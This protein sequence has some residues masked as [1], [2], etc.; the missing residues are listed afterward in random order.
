MYT[1]DSGVVAASLITFV[2]L[3]NPP[4]TQHE[5]CVLPP[6]HHA[7]TIFMTFTYDSGIPII[8]GTLDAAGAIDLVPRCSIGAECARMTRLRVAS[9]VIVTN[10]LGWRYVPLLTMLQGSY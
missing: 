3:N 8:I 4:G 9:T 1:N 7:R 10:M 5:V 6:A 2:T